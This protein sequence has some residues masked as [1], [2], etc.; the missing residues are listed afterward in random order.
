M[1]IGIHHAQITIPKGKESE[2]RDFY[3]GVLKLKEIP[4]PKLLQGCDSFWLQVGDK[5]VHVGG[6]DS[7]NRKLKSGGS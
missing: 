5:Q 7:E 3:C 6:E 4:K 2:V 1:I